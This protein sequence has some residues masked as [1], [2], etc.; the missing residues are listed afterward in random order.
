MSEFPRLFPPRVRRMNPKIRPVTR[1]I[2][3]PPNPRKPAPLRL[4]RFAIG[5][6]LSSLIHAA[7]ATAEA[8]HKQ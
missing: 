2:I 6:S 4:D 7:D 5:P 1:D 3:K 8:V